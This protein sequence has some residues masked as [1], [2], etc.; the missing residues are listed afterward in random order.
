MKKWND[1]LFKIN[2]ELSSPTYQKITDCFIYIASSKNTNYIYVL[3]L[4]KN[5]PGCIIYYDFNL[6]CVEHKSVDDGIKFIIN[7]EKNA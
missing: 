2:F 1:E 3:K 5:K 6:K 4:F 7:R